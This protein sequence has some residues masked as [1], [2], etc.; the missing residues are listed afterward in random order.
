MNMEASLFVRS[1]SEEWSFSK[2]IKARGNPTRVIGSNL[3]NKVLTPFLNHL[4]LY[5]VLLY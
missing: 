4:T 2:T 5:I 3:S 1:E